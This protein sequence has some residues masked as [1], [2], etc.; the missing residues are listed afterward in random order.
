[1]TNAASHLCQP[2]AARILI[3]SRHLVRQQT[4]GDM[5]SRSLLLDAARILNGASMVLTEMARLNALSTKATSS[6]TRQLRR[7]PT[8][9][10]ARPSEHVPGPDVTSP[11]V[12]SPEQRVP[13]VN[14][15]R[16][17][18]PSEHVPGPDVPSPVQRAPAPTRCMHAAAAIPS[19]QR[20]APF[21]DGSRTRD[22]AAANASAVICEDSS[23]NAGPPA[24]APAPFAPFAPA[25]PAPPPSS[26]APTPPV[27]MKPESVAVPS[28]QLARV[29]GFGTLATRLAL[30]T[31]GELV[32]RQFDQIAEDNTKR[33]VL[34][35]GNL[36]ALASTLCRM[37]GAALKLGQMLSMADNNV[38][39]PELT[40]ALDRVRQNADRMPAPQ[41]HETMATE[42]GDDWRAQFLEFEDLPLAAASLGQ[43]HRAKCPT[44]LGDAERADATTDMSVDTDAAPDDVVV[45]V[46]YPGVADSID[47]DIAN[48]MRLVRWT[49]F[50]PPGLYIDEVM[51]VAR[52][53][54]KLECDYVHEAKMQTKYRKLLMDAQDGG[55]APESFAFR[56][57]RVHPAF[58]TERVIT[59]EF[60]HGVALDQVSSLSQETRD[61]VGASLLWL[62]MTELFTWRFMQTDPNWGNFL[63]EEETSTVGLI[64]FGAAREFSVEF[65]DQYL[66][67]VWGAAEGDREL[68]LDASIQLGFLTG[69]ESQDMIEAHLAAAAVIGEPFACEGPYDFAGSDLTERVTSHL[70]VFGRERLA[71]PP[72]DA[73]AL[74]RKLSGS[75][76]ACI[77]LGARIECRSLLQQHYE[78]RWGM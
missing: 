74:H 24:P 40:Q 28:T 16:P 33:A 25:P 78:K 46:Q 75:F 59:T 50:A 41:L 77:K 6:V 32:R 5:T 61:E 64:D 73:Y 38:V 52:K 3:P 76:M 63:Y 21:D 66:R 18:E 22:T 1:L 13:N 19:S 4:F 37:R 69:D 53:E 27:S 62:T 14:M 71:P 48:V 67:L 26:A 65:I 45:K 8:V 44:R 54:L 57:P 23:G 60:I 47:S 58:S 12:T 31:V 49:N 20:D 68:I 15:T 36:D 9:D 30:G 51:R 56:V 2:D 70:H 35:D 72:E 29:M 7:V 39:P 10:M 55:N 34:S 17:F 43:V 42:L 11:D